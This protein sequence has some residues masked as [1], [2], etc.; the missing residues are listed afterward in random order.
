V[1]IQRQWPEQSQSLAAAQRRRLE[2]DTRG[3]IEKAERGK[4][5]RSTDTG[6]LI[7][8]LPRK[9]LSHPPAGE[10]EEAFASCKIV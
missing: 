8:T 6:T 4:K 1:S 3:N 9:I 5:A 10:A 2:R 7:G